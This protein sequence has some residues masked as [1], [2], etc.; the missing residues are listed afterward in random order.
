MEVKL[1]KM[2]V[3]GDEDNWAN[4]DT[5]WKWKHLDNWR[6]KLLRVKAIKNKTTKK[7]K[8]YFT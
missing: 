8:Y 1:L 3:I 4:S 2:K 7:Q 5:F 6:Q